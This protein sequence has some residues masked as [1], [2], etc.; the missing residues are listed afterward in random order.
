MPV[1]IPC[2]YQ[3]TYWHILH[4]I[5]VLQSPVASCLIYSCWLVNSPHRWF[6]AT[7]IPHLRDA[8]D[9]TS[10]PAVLHINLEHSSRHINQRRTQKTG[11]LFWSLSIFHSYCIEFRYC[12]GKTFFFN[13][14][15]FQLCSY[16]CTSIGSCRI[17]KTNQ[18]TAVAREQM[19]A[20]QAASALHSMAV[21]Q[22]FQ[23]RCSPMRKLV[24]IQLYSG[25]WG[26]QQ[27]WLYA[28]PKPPPR[29]SGIRCPA[30]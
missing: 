10:C 2:Q 30:W 12:M 18:C 14:T 13:W 19:A 27:T 28:P 20:G 17:K 11:M 29:P 5:S 26:A 23:A 1:G 6:T 25:T 8:T 21:I 22:V 16:K 24:W 4:I 9:C 15:Q 3:I 7:P